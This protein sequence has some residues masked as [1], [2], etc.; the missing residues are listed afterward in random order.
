MRLRF[1]SPFQIPFPRQKKKEHPLLFLLRK[2]RK[3][4]NFLL[5]ENGKKLPLI[6]L[7]ELPAKMQ[8]AKR[9]EKEL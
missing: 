9:Y 5:K 4:Q 2:K 3:H 8:R 6:F 7:V 1:K